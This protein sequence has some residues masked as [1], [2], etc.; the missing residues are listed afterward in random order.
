MCTTKITLKF[1]SN[2]IV[3]NKISIKMIVIDVDRFESKHSKRA[4]DQVAK[5]KKRK[6][7]QQTK[8]WMNVG[9]ADNLLR[10]NWPATV[11]A[12][13]DF[14]RIFFFFCLMPFNT[15]QYLSCMIQIFIVNFESAKTGAQ[16]WRKEKE[17][18]ALNLVHSYGNRIG[19]YCFNAL[20]WLC[21]SS[22]M[23]M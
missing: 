20:K 5:K 6:K 9:A 10:S 19:F 16:R 23:E 2:A 12:E 22:S 7:K 18:F 3:V 17:M 14:W 21:S 13:L 15:S 8:L 1:H 4:Q 11:G